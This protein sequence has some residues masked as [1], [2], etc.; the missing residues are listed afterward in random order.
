MTRKIL[1]TGGA[2]YIG[3]HTYAALC[4]AGYDVAILD[5]FDNARPDVPD[6]LEVITGKPVTVHRCDVLDTAA[7]ARV[8]AS[9]RFD[10]VVHFAARKVHDVD[11]VPHAGAIGGGVIIAKDVERGKLAGGDLGDVGH[12]VVGNVRRILAQQ[13]WQYVDWRRAPPDTA[14]PH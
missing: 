11:I 1:L 10:G 5:N 4:E 3:S 12:Q 2:G 14:R 7:L 8:F 9:E 6:R 13:R